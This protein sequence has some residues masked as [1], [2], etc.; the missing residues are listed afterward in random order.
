MTL[1]SDIVAPTVYPAF[2]FDLEIDPPL[3]VW[4]GTGK[5][6]VDDTLYLPLS[7]L[8]SGI[9]V[10]ETMGGATLGSSLRI[11]GQQQELL[12]VALNQPVQGKAARLWLAA[13][14]R[15]EAFL[16][17]EILVDDLIAD[18]PI[19]LTDEKVEIEIELQPRFD[20]ARKGPVLRWAKQSQALIDPDDTL[21]DFVAALA[22]QEIKFGA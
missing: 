11:T 14:D 6:T 20:V 12:G 13:T 16:S 7:G 8:D 22:G 19:S 4:T 21:F 15:N 3:H 18:M 10:T 1:E 17:R 5:V 9:A 2:M